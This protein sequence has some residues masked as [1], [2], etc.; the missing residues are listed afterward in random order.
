MI[1]TDHD[2][3][4]RRQVL[5]ANTRFSMSFDAK[6]WPGSYAH[7]PYRIAK[8]IE[9]IDLYEHRRVIDECHAE[10]ALAYTI[11]RF[12]SWHGLDPVGPRTSVT[13][14]GPSQHIQ[15][16]VIPNG[17]LIDEMFAI[18][19]LGDRTVVFWRGKGRAA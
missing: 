7:R 18:K 3:V 13:I 10:L 15:Q 16:P 14:D 17:I 9:A 19:C 5:E 1:V 6:P 12:G 2:Y 8:N 4:N 11:R